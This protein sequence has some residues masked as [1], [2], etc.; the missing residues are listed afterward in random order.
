MLTQ[1]LFAAFFHPHISDL[2]QCGTC[3]ESVVAQ[4]PMQFIS[5]EATEDGLPD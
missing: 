3:R 4:V 5:A 2:N 1:A